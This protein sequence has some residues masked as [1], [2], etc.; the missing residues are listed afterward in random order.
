MNNEFIL[1]NL[2]YLKDCEGKWYK[3]DKFLEDSLDSLYA[4]RIEQTQLFIKIIK[5]GKLYV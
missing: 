3:K 4:R 1:K 2:E 5:Q